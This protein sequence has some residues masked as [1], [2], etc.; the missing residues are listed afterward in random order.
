MTVENSPKQIRRKRILVALVGVSLVC[1]LFWDQAE[2]HSAEQRIDELP[3]RGFGYSI[4]RMEL[5]GD[6]KKVYE[7][8]AAW[9]MMVRAGGQDAVLFVVDGTR[10]RHAV[11]HPEFCLRGSGWTV[12]G[13]RNLA[14]TDSLTVRHIDMH[15]GD[16]QSDALYWFSD[17]ESAWTSMNRYWMSATMRRVSLGLSGEEPVMIILQPVPGRPVDWKRLFDCCP[18]LAQI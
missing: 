17:A 13:S 4:V 16:L 12:N 7:G 8:V 15:Q 5:S 1:G 6:Q 2:L 14:V 10:N 9:R 18:A 11:H 3:G